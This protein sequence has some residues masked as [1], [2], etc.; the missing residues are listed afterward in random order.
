MHRT[1]MT[2]LPT[3]TLCSSNAVDNDCAGAANRIGRLLRANSGDF[4]VVE[5]VAL[6]GVTN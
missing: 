5:Q 6:C 1:E 4:L 3:G 2:R